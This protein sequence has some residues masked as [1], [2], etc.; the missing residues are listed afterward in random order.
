[1]KR[2][3]YFI[4][5]IIFSIIIFFLFFKNDIKENKKN[6]VEN[7]KKT[8]VFFCDNNGRIFN[9]EKEAKKYNTK[10]SEYGATYCQYYQTKPIK[11]FEYQKKLKIGVDVD[12]AKTPKS[13]KKYSEKA[14]KEFK[15]K[16][17]SH[18]RIRVKEYDID[19][20]LPQIK[21][22]VS[23][24]L[25]N[26]LIPILAFGADD[27]KKNPDEKEKTKFV[28]WWKK[29][30]FEMKNYSQD[31]SFDLIIEV[32]DSL[33]KK[34]EILNSTYEEAIKEI[35]KTNPERNIFISPVLRSAPENLKLLKIPTKANNHLLAEF[36]FYASG[37]SKENPKKKWTVGSENEKKI[38]K[39]KIKDALKWQKEN[40]IS[41][42]VGAWMPGNYNK[43]NDYTVE[44]QVKFAKF[45]SEELKKAKIPFAINSDH[46]FYNY[47]ENTWNKKMEKV[48]NVILE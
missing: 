3:L 22:V 43:G 20:I 26:D 9:N 27:F 21:K 16:G 1:M 12:W 28:E 6:I 48:L 13:I 8:E 31:L 33:N 46:F 47:E 10:T 41:V 15:K 40:N 35:R 29:I 44:E 39:N 5:F 23:D 42:W 37:P 34:P 30:A 38:I 2:N 45:V 7:N 11:P 14:V 24:C 19:K 18:V 4:L 17:F 36:H 32:T 25:R